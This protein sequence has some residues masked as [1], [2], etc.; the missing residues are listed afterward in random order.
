MTKFLDV[1]ARNFAGDPAACRNAAGALE[2]V[3]RRRSDLSVEGHRGLQCDQRSTTADVAREPFVQAPRFLY[4][5][6]D[7]YLHPGGAEL[8]ESPAAYFR[9][10][11]GHGGNYAM[12][13]RLDQR[14]RA[15]RGASLMSMR[16]EIDV[17]R[18]AARLRTCC[19]Q[20]EDFCVF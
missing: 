13:A 10:G 7:F 19:F 15:G 14:V 17:E 3:G 9:I 11:I 1:G 16:F 5:A 18:S 4:E 2:R 12:D 6:S 20:G 8:L